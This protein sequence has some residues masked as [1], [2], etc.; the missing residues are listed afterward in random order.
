MDSLIP[1]LEPVQNA[2]IIVIQA[3]LQTQVLLDHLDHLLVGVKNYAPV[4]FGHM[5]YGISGIRVIR[6]IRGIRDIRDIRGIRDIRC[7]SLKN[8][9]NI[10]FYIDISI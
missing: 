6:D 5:V 9:H 3:V 2:Y 8:Y 1:C 10:K 4:N 7:I